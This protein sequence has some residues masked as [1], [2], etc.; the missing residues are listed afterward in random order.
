V[1]GEDGAAVLYFIE[2]RMRISVVADGRRSTL[3]EIADTHEAFV[4]AVR[5]RLESALPQ[6]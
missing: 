3:A 1:T 6:N 5:E 4:K 2:G